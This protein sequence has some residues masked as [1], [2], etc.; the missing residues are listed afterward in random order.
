M[1]LSY[2]KIVSLFKFFQ[3]KKL[4]YIGIMV[5]HQTEVC[6]LQCL[7]RDTQE[8]L[9]VQVQTTVDQVR[10]NVYRFVCVCMYTH[11]RTRAKLYIYFFFIY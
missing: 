4:C 3:D 7:L 9:R 6:E 1:L 5:Q 11:A 8:R 2:F 10:Y